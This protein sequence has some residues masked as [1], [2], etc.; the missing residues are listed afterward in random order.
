MT[1]PDQLVDDTGAGVVDWTATRLDRNTLLACT[2]CA[3]E[4]GEPCDSDRPDFC[5]AG[6]RWS[7]GLTQ[8]GSMMG[9]RSVAA[10]P[11]CSPTV[12][13]LADSD[14]GSLHRGACLSAACGWVGRSRDNENTAVEDVLDHTHAGWRELPIVE[15]AT[16]DASGAQLDGWRR[17]VNRIYQ[18]LGHNDHLLLP[19]GVIRTRRRRHA[20]RSHWSHAVGGYDVYGGD[21]LDDQ[22]RSAPTPH[23]ALTLF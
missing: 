10:T 4:A 14:R 12:E 2:I 3:A 13:H 6:R 9:R 5:H 8:P 15:R 16:H 11:T 22:R 23:R 18:N 17:D 1:A 7:V 21:D 20:T 19:G